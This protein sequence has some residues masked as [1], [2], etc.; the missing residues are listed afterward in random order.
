MTEKPY[1]CSKNRYLQSGVS[2]Q[3]IRM[4]RFFT[5]KW[6]NIC[7]CGKNVVILRRSIRIE[8]TFYNS[9]LSVFLG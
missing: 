4:A 3:Y 2:C 5:E 9:K 7:V 1:L 8:Q 6:K